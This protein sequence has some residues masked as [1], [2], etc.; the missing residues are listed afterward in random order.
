M[1]DKSS[2]LEV[3]LELY[4]AAGL[5]YIIFATFMWLA[6]LNLLGDQLSTAGRKRG[7]S[8]YHDGALLYIYTLIHFKI[9]LLRFNTPQYTIPHSSI[10]SCS[11][12]LIMTS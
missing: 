8:K 4:V 9:S 6:F 1:L 11:N 12:L 5:D 10:S 3:N 2:L 7:P